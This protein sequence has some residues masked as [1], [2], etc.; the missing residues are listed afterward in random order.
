[1]GQKDVARRL[2]RQIIEKFPGTGVAKKA[3]AKLK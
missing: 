3:T 1:M 2:Y